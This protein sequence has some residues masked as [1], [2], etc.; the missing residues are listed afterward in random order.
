[1]AKEEKAEVLKEQRKQV[2]VGVVCDCSTCV[3]CHILSGAKT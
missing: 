1:M 2:M 3:T